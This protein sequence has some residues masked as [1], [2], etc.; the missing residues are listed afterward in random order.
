[1]I[2]LFTI[3]LHLRSCMLSNLG[4][5]VESADGPGDAVRDGA[6]GVEVPII[7]PAKLLIRNG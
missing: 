2:F 1:M 7:S 5:V 6:S 3:M 4:A